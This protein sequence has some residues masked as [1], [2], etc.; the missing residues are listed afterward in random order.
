VSNPSVNEQRDPSNIGFALP[1]ANAWI[2]DSQDHSKLAAVGCIGE[3]LLSGPLLAREYINNPLKTEEAF[4]EEPSW[5]TAYHTSTSSKVTTSPILPEQVSK[6]RPMSKL[7]RMYKTGDLVRYNEDGS[8]LFIGRK[9]NQVKLHGQRMELGE[10]EHSLDQDLDI[11]HALVSLPKA[12]PFRKR[13]V[14]VISLTTLATTELT[15]SACKLILD[16]PQAATSCTQVSRARARLSAL[17]PPYMIPL[18]WLV[19]ESVP[20]LPSGKLDRRHVETWLQNIDKTTYEQILQAEEAD[21]DDT[22]MTETGR[23]LQQIISRV[24][25]LPIGRVPLNKSFL[26]LGGDSITSM[27]VMAHCRKES[28]NYSLTDVL[29][30][31]S[32]HQLAS[33]AR[34]EDKVQQQEEVPD[35]DFDLSPIQ[36][37]YVQSQASQNFQGTCRFNQSFS[38]EI[39]RPIKP[40][41]LKVAVRKIVDQHSMLRA[42]FR[43]NP[44]GSWQQRVSRESPG[45]TYEVHDVEQEQEIPRLINNS[46]TSLDIDEG[47]VFRVD[48]FNIR[49]TRQMVSLVAHHLVID[50]VS[51]RI[52][53]QDLEEILNTGS[54]SSEK[55]LPFQVWCSMQQAHNQKNASDAVVT[56]LPFIVPPPELEYWQLDRTENTYREVICQTFHIDEEV[57]SLALGDSNRPFQT[58]PIELFLAAITH[59]FSRVFVDRDIPAVF[60]ESHG[61]EPWDASIDISRT[62]GWFTAI[63]PVHV[64]V[65]SEQDDVLDTV[66]RMKDTRRSVPYNGRPSFA[67][68]FLTGQLDNQGR[69]DNQSHQAPMEILFNYLGR[70]QQLEADDALLQQWN[71]P[72]DKETSSLVS[73]V[74][75]EATRL[76]LFEISAA[77]IQDKIQFT[78]LYNSGMEHRRRIEKWVMECQDTLKEIVRCLASIKTGPSYTLSDFPLLRIS[79][80]GLQK[81]ITKTLPQVGILQDN[82][83]DIYPSAPMQEGVLISQL[84]NPTLYHVH[85]VF[86]VCPAEDNVPVNPE[87]LIHAWQKVVD[88]HAALR[89]IFADSVTKGDIFNQVVVKKV[90]SGVITIRCENSEALEKLNSM[91]I[92]DGNYSK[93]PRLPHQA[94]ICETPEGK[95]YFKAEVNHAIIDGTSANIILRDLIEAYHGRLPTGPGPLFSD[96][97]A[98]I[99][100]HAAKASINFW[101]AYLDGIQVCNFPT[102]ANPSPEKRSLASIKMQFERFPAMQDMCQKLSVTMASVMQT[103]WAFCLSQYTKSDEVAFGYLTSG[104]DVPVKGVQNAIGAFINILVCRVKFMKHATLKEVFHK[105]Q[106][107]Y[108]ESLEHQ[109]CSLAQ[110]QHDL[111][112]G[113]AMFN[114]AVS[115]Q[116][117]APSDGKEKESISFASLIA[118]DPSEVLFIPMSIV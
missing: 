49:K 95:V 27:Q 54:L 18:S 43:K 79:Y 62:V 63:F 88:R 89:T 15:N 108:L 107:D 61:R 100:R 47:P 44:K 90:D 103:A 59:S 85:A 51:W 28:I 71:F 114:T 106:N 1:S 110:V 7:G 26:S 116:S 81:M 13:L 101:K 55:P 57:T 24:L 50:M 118:H 56:G 21:E 33:I 2:A 9:D 31:K 29:K 80:E 94:I 84:K 34:H 16:G 91:S 19:V 46:Q 58:E 86:E 11:R 77:V 67:R 97:I 117:D 83:E 14:A 112:S 48:L 109:H 39:T 104:R 64:S 93:Y 12:G 111:M 42:K 75:P 37:L 22:P 99:K 115:I 73:D 23:I 8:M 105:V 45:G 82:I 65:D 53:I 72:D 113:Q 41:D 74:G 25:N 87:Q 20:L 92:L 6:T 40:G 68:R 76:A 32:I 52:I 66:R 60:N 36:Q 78:F 70:M 3:L 98:Y 38:L 17:L 69:L 96:Y 30:S 102:L 5:A 4:I 35:Q 10:I